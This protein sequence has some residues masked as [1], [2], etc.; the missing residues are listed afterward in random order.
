MGRLICCLGSLKISAIVGRRD[1]QSIRIVNVLFG[2]RL[3]IQVL[4]ELPGAP[5]EPW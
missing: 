3:M 2:F 5:M 1:P 4:N